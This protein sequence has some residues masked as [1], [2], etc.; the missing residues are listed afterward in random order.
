MKIFSNT[1]SKNVILTAAL[2]ALSAPIIGTA[3]AGETAEKT[4]ST[5]QNVAPI[6]KTIAA[7]EFS[8]RSKHETNGTVKLVQTAT[9]YQLVLGSDFFLDGAPDPV[10]ALGNNDTFLKA[11]KLA[12]LSK[13][14][15]AQVYD[16]PAGFTPTQ[17]SQAY[18]WCERFNVPLG[19]ADLT[20]S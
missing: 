2:I 16:L 1:A 10:V 17:F 15:G 14:A 11:N 5:E 12:P 19:I 3:M 20:K 7:G 13:K 8:G 18:I 6:A 4:Y 9:G